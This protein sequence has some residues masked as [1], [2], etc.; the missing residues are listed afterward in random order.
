MMRNTKNL[1]SSHLA[2][3]TFTSVDPPSLNKPRSYYV[4]T[5]EIMMHILKRFNVNDDTS[6][7]PSQSLK[8]EPSVNQIRL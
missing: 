3:P 8:E 6:P 5:N 1:S 4:H 7:K 2:I